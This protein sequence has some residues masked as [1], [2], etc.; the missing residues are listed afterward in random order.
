MEINDACYSGKYRPPRET[1]ATMIS[2]SDVLT[3]RA[4]RAL[5]P[6]IIL[7][8]AIVQNV[9]QPY[10]WNIAVYPRYRGRGV[11]SSLLEEII[12]RYTNEKSE[13]I[14]LHVNATNPAQKLYF[15][16]G[17]RVVNVEKKYFDP[18]DGLVMVRQ[19]P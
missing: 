12:R 8:F 1:V 13:H 7:G 18:D 4:H 2:V 9:A 11:A 15:D 6:E 10:L 5:D 16:H 3:A 17:F 19:L 14:T